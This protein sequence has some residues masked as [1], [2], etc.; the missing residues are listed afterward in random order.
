MQ[1]RINSQKLL[2]SVTFHSLSTRIHTPLTYILFKK[3]LIPSKLNTVKSLKRSSKSNYL[4]IL[5]F[6]M[7]LLHAQQITYTSFQ[8]NQRKLI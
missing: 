5:M 4:I 8:K 3:Q 7:L 1:V 6:Y 2:I